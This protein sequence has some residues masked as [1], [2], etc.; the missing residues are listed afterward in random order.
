[1]EEIFSAG[2]FVIPTSLEMRLYVEELILEFHGR[3]VLKQGRQDKSR[4]KP[5]LNKRENN[6]L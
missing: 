5:N 4:H 3:C 2:K 6:C 1:M